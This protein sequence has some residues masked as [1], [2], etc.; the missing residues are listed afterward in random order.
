MTLLLWLAFP[1]AVLLAYAALGKIVISW[2]VRAGLTMVWVSA[3]AFVDSVA[4]GR[5]SGV[6]AFLGLTGCVYALGGAW[7]GGRHDLGVLSFFAMVA[8]LGAPVFGVVTLVV[9]VVGFVYHRAQV[10]WLLV[11]LPALAV[12]IQVSG[13]LGLAIF[14]RLQ[15]RLNRV[16]VIPVRSFLWFHLTI[17]R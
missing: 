14:S 1:L 13:L 7:R 6:V 10:R 4:T 17:F 8:S 9:G 11:P 16:F 2:Y 12:H 5:I 3:P 15:E